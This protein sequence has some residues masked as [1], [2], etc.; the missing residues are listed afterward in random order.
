MTIE[1]EFYKFLKNYTEE[2]EKIPYTYKDDKYP[3]KTEI[4]E[5]FVRNV[6]DVYL[7]TQKYDPDNPDADEFGYV[8]GEGRNEND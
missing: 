4:W 6:E 1:K 7:T 8:Y 3:T 5:W 2:M